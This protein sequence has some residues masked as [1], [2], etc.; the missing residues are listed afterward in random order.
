MV[1]IGSCLCSV[2]AWVSESTINNSDV[3]KTGLPVSN[4]RSIYENEPL[5]LPAKNSW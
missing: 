1:L 3:S 4:G 2:I 5:V